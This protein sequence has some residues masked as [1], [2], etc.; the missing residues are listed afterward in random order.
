MSRRM[1]PTPVA[2]PWK[3]STALGWLCDSTLNA[4][5]SPPPTSTAPAFS[6]GPM[7]TCAPSVGSV[8]SSFLECLY[9]QCSLHSSEYIA[10]SS[11][12]G[13]RPCCSHTSS[14]SAAVSPSASASWSDGATG[15]A[16]PGPGGGRPICDRFGLSGT[17]A[18]HR[19]AHRL[20]DPQPVRR[21]TD[22]LIDR[23]LGMGHQAEHVS[24]L[25]AHARD[26]PQRPVEVL[27]RRV[28]QHDLA[29]LLHPAEHLLVGVVAPPRVLRRDA[30]GLAR[31][32]A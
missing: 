14:Y 27:A 1:P 29:A 6:P 2:A 19:Q 21:A 15:V 5:A 17:R 9:A 11:T 30:Q 4:H 10:S 22:Q 28:A 16:P 25:V 26:V 3:G 8:R 13:G 23:V 12:F 24:G 31:R 7:T 20:E 32:P 18:L